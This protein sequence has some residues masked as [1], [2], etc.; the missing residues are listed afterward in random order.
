M[1]LEN[2]YKYDTNYLRYC[3]DLNEI[4][5]KIPRRVI[6]LDNF[7]VFHYRFWGSSSR[8][9]VELAPYFTYLK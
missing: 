8:F 9:L 4:F 3:N 7:T 5:S 1:V 2:K 6:N